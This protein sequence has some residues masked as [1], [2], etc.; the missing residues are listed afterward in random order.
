MQPQA[1][2]VEE[3]LS[4]LPAE[5]QAAVRTLRDT[6]RAALPPGFEERMNYGMVGYVVPHS[7][8]PAGYH[9]DPKAPLPFMGLASQ[10]ASVNLYHMGLYADPALLAWFTEAHA[11]ASKRKLDMGK[12]CIRYKKP[13]DMPLALLAELAGKM[14]VEAWIAL[15]EGQLKP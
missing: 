14:T 10:K 5:R 8:Y 13:E 1:Q 15:Y 7:L 2:T 11:T 6:L 3:Y 9:C 4:E 12:S